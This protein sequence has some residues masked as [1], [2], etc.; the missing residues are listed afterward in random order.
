MG[1]SGSVYRGQLFTGKA[2]VGQGNLEHHEQVKKLET[3]RK[4]RLLFLDFVF[5]ALFELR[6]QILIENHVKH[7]EVFEGVK[8]CILEDKNLVDQRLV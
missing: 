4:I 3:M 1:R 8:G 7:F 2:G 6:C 5:N